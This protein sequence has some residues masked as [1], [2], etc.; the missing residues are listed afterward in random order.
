MSADRYKFPNTNSPAEFDHAGVPVHATPLI[1]LNKA[2]GSSHWQVSL[3]H[4]T[5]PTKNGVDLAIVPSQGMTAKNTVLTRSSHS[6]K[7][8]MLIHERVIGLLP[9][10]Q[11]KHSPVEVTTSGLGTKSRLKK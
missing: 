11:G 3:E 9:M 7:T 5:V 8:M 1:P 6:R 4:F 10:L 2:M